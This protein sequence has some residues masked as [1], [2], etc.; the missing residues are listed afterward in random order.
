MAGVRAECGA[1]RVQLAPEFWYAQ[2]RRFALVAIQVAGQSGFTNPF[3]SGRGWTADYPLR[4]GNQPLFVIDPGQTM[5]EA[6]VRPV[7]V[8]VST[9]SQWWGPGLRNGLLLSN[10][11]AGFPNAY[12]RTAKPV[13]TPLGLVEARWMVG[14]LTESRFYDFAPANDLRSISGLIVSLQT[15]AD[16]NLTIG[17]ARVVY[18]PIGTAM[19]LPAR[20]LDAVARWGESA[21]V[22]LAQEGRGADQLASLFARW[23]FPE[24][25]FEAYG[26]WARMILPSSLRSFVLSPQ[27][28]Q[29]YTL[30]LQWLGALP[31]E[32]TA[33]RAQAEITDLEQPFVTRAVVPPT[34]YVSPTVGQGY[35]ERGQMIGARIGPGSSSQFAAVDR[36]GRAGRVGVFLERVRWANDAF[37]LAPTGLSVWAHDVSLIAGVRAGRNTGAFE[38]AVEL[39]AERRLNYLFQNA[40]VGFDEDATFDARNLSLRFSLE[41]RAR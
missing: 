41:P 17:A 3:F 33:W 27:F 25:G 29:G 14:A 11:A 18:A 1:I 37:F 34:F 5:I 36:L 40:K 10:H 15:R 35:T 9:E 16:S 13:K 22:R 28:S 30:G 8:G 38:L 19:A 2:N 31:T 7:T 4:F 26:E 6:D 32:R 21:D 20:F 23:L 39:I 12:V 24:S